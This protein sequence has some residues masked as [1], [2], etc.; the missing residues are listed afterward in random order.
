GDEATDIGA[1]IRDAAQSGI[2]RDGDMR[3]ER[4]PCRIDIA[5]PQ[6]RAIAL[7]PRASVA[8]KGVGTLVGAP[9]TRAVPIHANAGEPRR[10]AETVSL[11]WPPAIDAHVEER[12]VKR[13]VA[14]RL[15]IV[16]P[17]ARGG[18]TPRP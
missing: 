15:A 6:K 12:F 1:P 8:M 11:V 3:P 9:L 2:D 7:H 18:F 10:G 17:R 4:F 13:P 16:W 14:A 5:R